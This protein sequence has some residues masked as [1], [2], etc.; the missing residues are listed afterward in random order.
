[1]QI[2]KRLHLILL[3]LIMRCASEASHFFLVFPREKNPLHNGLYEHRL[4]KIKNKTFFCTRYV[5]DS[6]RSTILN[7]HGTNASPDG[8]W[9]RTHNNEAFS[10]WFCCKSFRVDRARRGNVCLEA[11]L[12]RVY[13]A[14]NARTRYK[15]QYNIPKLFFC[16]LDKKSAERGLSQQLYLQVGRRCP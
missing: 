8:L 1:M 6:I 15:H 16:V 13:K 12:G 3:V 10:C 2:R 11:W 7:A 5:C 14:W 9:T 4:P